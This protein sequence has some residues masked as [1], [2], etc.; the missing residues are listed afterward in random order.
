MTQAERSKSMNSRAGD[1]QLRQRDHEARRHDAARGL[2]QGREEKVERA[3]RPRVQL[4]GHRLDGDAPE[5]R[6]RSI[7]VPAGCLARAGDGVPVFLVVGPRAV[8][9]DVGGLNGRGRRLLGPEQS[10]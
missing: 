6:Q 4:L 2:E 5:R 3:H 7:G 10:V 9:R 8:P 1:L